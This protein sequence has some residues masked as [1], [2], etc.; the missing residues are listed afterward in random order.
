MRVGNSFTAEDAAGGHAA[1][2]VRVEQEKVE[3]TRFMLA[4]DVKSF[5]H[6]RGYGG[7]A[8][9]PLRE[10]LRVFRASA[11]D[12]ES[13]L[14]RGVICFFLTRR[15]EDTKIPAPGLPAPS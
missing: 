7:R 6:R 1:R 3:Q 13:R 14:R 4:H 15:A 10:F 2:E 8:S 12:I 9:R 11:R 5:F